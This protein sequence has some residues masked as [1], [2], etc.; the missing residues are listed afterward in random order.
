[1]AIHRGACHC[2]A[3]TFEVEAPS[4][5]HALACNCSICR[6]CGYVQVI[7]PRESLRIL[8]G[9]DELTTYTFNT[10]VAKHTF[11]RTCGVKPFYTP[12]SNPDG[13]AVNVY[14]LEPDAI[15]EVIVEPFDGQNWEQHAHG[16]ADRSRPR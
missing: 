15:D 14:C 4:V 2:G 8:T 12:R 13:Y 3:V 9:E 7:V 11:C 1:M 5:L 10:H 6:P 16:L